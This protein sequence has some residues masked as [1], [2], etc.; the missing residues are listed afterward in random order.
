MT[1]EG[2]VNELPVGVKSSGI[3]GLHIEIGSDLFFITKVSEVIFP[4]YKFQIF[5]SFLIDVCHKK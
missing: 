3:S 5:Q 1:N 2:R 4:V